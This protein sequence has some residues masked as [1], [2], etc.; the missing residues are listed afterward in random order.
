MTL[1][2]TKNMLFEGDR[3]YVHNGDIFIG[4]QRLYSGKKSIKDDKLIWFSN[5]SAIIM[6]FECVC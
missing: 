4:E 6:Y 1:Y 5:I 2:A 3:V